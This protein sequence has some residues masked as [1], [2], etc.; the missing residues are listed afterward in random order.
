[1]TKKLKHFLMLEVKTL[2]IV[3]LLV[4]FLTKMPIVDH[5]EKDAINGHASQTERLFFKSVS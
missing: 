3:F 4:Y 2:I 5:C 1:M